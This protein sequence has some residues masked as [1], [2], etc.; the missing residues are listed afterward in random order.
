MLAQ[1]WVEEKPASTSDVLLRGRRAPGDVFRMH[2]EAPEKPA[3][4]VWHRVA[5]QSVFLE[6]RRGFPVPEV[7]KEP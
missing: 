2:L 5:C 1:G 4:A 7:A 3:G 6:S